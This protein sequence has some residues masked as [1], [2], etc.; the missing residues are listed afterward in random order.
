MIDLIED[1]FSPTWGRNHVLTVGG[2][3]GTKIF[4]IAIDAMILRIASNVKKEQ[5]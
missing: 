3:A 4:K 2:I 5:D 1:H